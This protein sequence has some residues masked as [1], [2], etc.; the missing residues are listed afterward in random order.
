M[1]KPQDL[2]KS[3]G[4]SN[5][6]VFFLVTLYIFF[7]ISGYLKYG[8]GIEE[9]ISLN[10]PYEVLSLVAQSLMSVALLSCIGIFFKC[11]IEIF[12]E[13]V[14]HKIP[15]DKHKIAEVLI[16]AAITFLIVILSILIPNLGIFISIIGALF[17][18]NLKFLFPALIQI[19]YLHPHYGVFKWRL[20]K[21]IFVSLF[22]IFTLIVGLYFSIL[23]IIKLYE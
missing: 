17:A 10:L 4:I 11:F 2:L 20:F 16:R 6:A 3:C 7:G 14:Q 8:D 21:N 13:K 9:S 1:K 18:S 23:D 12:W 5:I 19:A 22:S 15:K